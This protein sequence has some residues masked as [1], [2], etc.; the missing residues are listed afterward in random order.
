MPITCLLH[1]KP[2]KTTPK[3]IQQTLNIPV[4][5]NHTRFNRGSLY[6]YNRSFFLWYPPE[7]YVS[8]APENYSEVQEFFFA[9]KRTQRNHLMAMS[10]PTPNE[11]PP[12]EGMYVVR[13][14]RHHS[15]RGWRITSD[16]DDFNGSEEYSTPLFNKRWEYRIITYKGN[17]ICTLLKRAA[18]GRLPVSQPWNHINGTSFVTVRDP[19]NDRLRHTTV[20]QDIQTEFFNTAHLIGIDIMIDPN[21]NYCICEL[22]SCPAFTIP[23]NLEKLRELV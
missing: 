8:H 15:G 9:N 23:T 10:L 21:Y 11:F 14:L 6:N 2:F 17:V 7:E 5:R 18:T 1:P 22:N 20:Y 4:R 12:H 3:H 19:D 16:R 13:P